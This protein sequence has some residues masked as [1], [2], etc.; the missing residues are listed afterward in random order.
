MSKVKIEYIWIDG[1]QPTQKMRS[2][3]KVVDGPIDRLDQIPDWGFD[4][5][6]TMQAD[7]TDSDCM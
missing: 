7:G 5:S 2:K 6:S 1:H 4:G 3:T